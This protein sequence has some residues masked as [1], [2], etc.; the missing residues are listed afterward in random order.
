MESHGSSDD[1][2]ELAEELENACSR[3]DL[4]R[5]QKLGSAMGLDLRGYA[6]SWLLKLQEREERSEWEERGYEMR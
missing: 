4:E 6:M 3:V 1:V 2:Q 5:L